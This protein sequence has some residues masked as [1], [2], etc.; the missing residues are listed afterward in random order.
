MK[1][2][3]VDSVKD[4]NYY[5]AKVVIIKSSAF[6]H[7]RLEINSPAVTEG[8]TFLQ[9]QPVMFRLGCF[10]LKYLFFFLARHQFQGNFSVNKVLFKHI[11]LY[12]LAFKRVGYLRRTISV[13]CSVKAQPEGKTLYKI[14]LT[15]T[16][17]T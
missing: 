13:R 15:S 2:L 12:V 5:F 3:I 16:H 1:M 7:F 11:L 17:L 9:T 10:S 6:V 8:N 4:F 14:Q